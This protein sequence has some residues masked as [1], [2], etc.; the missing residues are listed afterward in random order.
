M[1]MPTDLLIA[2][3]CILLLSTLFAW[4][5]SS[6]RISKKWSAGL[7]IA[8]VAVLLLYAV[9]LGD[10]LLLARILPVADCLAWMNLQTPAMALLAGLAWSHLTGPRWQRNLLVG[11]LVVIGLWRMAAPYLGSK[12][13]FGP[14]KW[15]QGVCR[16]SNTS[17]CSAASAATVLAA[18]GIPTTERE[19]ADLCLTHVEGTTM[20][21]LYRG[22]KLKTAGTAWDVKILNCRPEDLPHQSL[23]AVIT[24][25]DPGAN[26]SW[27]SLGNRHSVVLLGFTSDGHADIG[28]PFAGRQQWTQKELNELYNGTGIAVARD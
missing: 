8:A 1:A 11:I 15:M 26:A 17:T 2:N 27:L 18:A 24:I 16:Q 22:L 25:S 20:L 14:D 21:G 23:P 12:P 7:A 10:N 19:M 28:D 9:W 3:A 13:I 6:K 5:G 4:L